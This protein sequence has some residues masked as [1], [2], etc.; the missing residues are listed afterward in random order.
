MYTHSAFAQENPNFYLAENEV[1]VMCPD[2]EVGETG[3]VDG[4]VYTK[5]TRDQITGPILIGACPH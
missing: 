3:E 5:R 4:V 2:A 1:T